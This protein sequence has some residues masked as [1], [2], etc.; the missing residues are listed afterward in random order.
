[1]RMMFHKAQNFPIFYKEKDITISVLTKMDSYLTVWILT[2]SNLST[3]YPCTP[4][5][6]QQKR[7]ELNVQILERKPIKNG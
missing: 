3:I 4:L 1:M 6:C 7:N 2:M 5:S